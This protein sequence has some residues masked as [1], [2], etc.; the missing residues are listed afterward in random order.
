MFVEEGAEVVVADLDS[1]KVDAAIAEFGVT[2]VAPHDIYKQEVDIF[3]P[4]ALGAVINDETIPQLRAKVIAGSANNIF[5]E[6]RHGMSWS[7]AVSST[8]STT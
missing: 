3:A 7:G 4:Y 2:S 6:E 5:A 1:Q 8:P